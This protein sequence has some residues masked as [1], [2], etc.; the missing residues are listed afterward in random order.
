MHY[1]GHYCIIQDQCTTLKHAV[2]GKYLINVLFLVTLTFSQ[3]NVLKLTGASRT[4]VLKCYSM[5]TCFDCFRLASKLTMPKLCIIY[6]LH[7]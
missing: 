6:L 5:A 2:P 4:S 7:T 3:V 1:L